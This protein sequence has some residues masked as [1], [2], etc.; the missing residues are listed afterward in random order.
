M[1]RRITRRESLLRIPSVSNRSRQRFVPVEGVV[2]SEWTTELLLKKGDT[3]EP[4]S[5]M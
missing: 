1:I 2:F 3:M 5:T 4:E